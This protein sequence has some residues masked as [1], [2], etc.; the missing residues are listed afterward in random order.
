MP[1]PVGC[2]SAMKITGHLRLDAY[3]CRIGNF[4]ENAAKGM[5]ADQRQC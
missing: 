1:Q 5:D 3:Q 2:A 4:P